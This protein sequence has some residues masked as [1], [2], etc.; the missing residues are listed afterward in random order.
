MPTIIPGVI[1]NGPF[2]PGKYSPKTYASA[3]SSAKDPKQYDYV[4]AGGG[5]AGAVL[6]NRL[7]AHGKHTVL[8]L[9]AGYTDIRQLWSRIP[10]AFSFLFQKDAD[11]FYETVPQPNLN[12][13]RLFWPR[14]KMLGGC[15]CR[16]FITRDYRTYVN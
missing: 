16:M 11:W 15:E 2:W 6:A 9:E 12:N 13:R 8:L 4:I 10:A 1:P 5:T 7:S 3:A 14:G